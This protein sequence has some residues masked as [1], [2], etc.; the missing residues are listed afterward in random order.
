MARLFPKNLRNVIGMLHLPALPGTPSAS[1]SV[2]EIVDFACREV[3][4]YARVGG[5]D[6]LIVENMNDLPYCKVKHI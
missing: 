6:A 1:K 5:V 4:T 2:Q 3:E